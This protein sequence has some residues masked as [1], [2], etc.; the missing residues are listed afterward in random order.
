MDKYLLKQFFECVCFLNSNIYLEHN[1]SFHN[2][3]KSCPSI[4]ISCL[5]DNDANT[6]KCENICFMVLT[7]ATHL[8]Y[9]HIFLLGMMRPDVSS[10]DTW[11]HL[12]VA[13]Y[14]SHSFGI[15]PK[16]SMKFI[17][18][19]KKF[20]LFWLKECFNQFLRQRTL[21]NVWCSKI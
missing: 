1:R 20:C 21:R 6:F 16:H 10:A 19:Q 8:W 11:Q 13:S 9:W 17:V 12:S 2:S 18:S 3:I 15:I 7:T 4:S 5:E 14:Q